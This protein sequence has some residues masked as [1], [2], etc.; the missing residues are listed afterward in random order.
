MINAEDGTVTLDVPISPKG[1]IPKKI[2]KGLQQL[3]VIVSNIP[4][5]MPDAFNFKVAKEFLGRV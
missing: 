4:N 2:L 5:N 3:G 1:E